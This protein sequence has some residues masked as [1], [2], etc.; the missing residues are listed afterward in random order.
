M[1]QSDPAKSLL[2]KV[3]AT[4]RQYRM[5]EP[6]GG[7]VVGVSG[8]P[9]SIALINILNALKSET[10]FRIV[11]AH[12][13]HGLREDSWKDAEFVREM[14]D[15]MDIPIEVVA[16]DVRAMA[17]N[18]GVSI[19]E[20]GRRCRYKFFED[21]RISSGA[22]VIA[23]AHHMDDEL[24][25]FFLRIF[26][27]S[28][29]RGMKGIAP[30]RGQI[31]RPLIRAERAEIISFLEARHLPYR[32]DPTNL[33]TETD[34]N[35]IRNR[36]F[37]AIRE[38]FSNFRDPLRRTL[39]MLAQEDEFLDAQ[40]KKLCSEAVSGSEDSLVLDVEK[41]RSAPNALT[42][43][44]VLLALYDSS[45][46]DER[47]SR[48]HIQALIKAL[49]SV[50]PSA[51]L[52]LPGGLVAKREYQTLRILREKPGTI[53][54][55]LDMIVTGPGEVEF[56]ETGFTLRFRLLEGDGRFP[57]APGGEATAFFD[58][59]KAAFPLTLRPF[60]PGDRIKP[61]GLDGSR[62]LKKLFIDMKVPAGL[63]RVIP[64]LVKEGE[65]LWVPGIRRGQAAAVTPETRRI[66]EVTLARG[67]DELTD[68]GFTR[69]D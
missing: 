32:V 69:S 52:D 23:T 48:S 12:M 20:A 4:I 24:E 2:S 35:F 62:K 46:R 49:Y 67:L 11:A 55:A 38:R 65:I 25:T 27:G 64:L 41:L 28:S 26:R 53:P 3:R 15:K 61:W 39:A 36:L 44:S 31:V 34:R 8:G 57:K 37:P 33:E 66:L 42:A 43:R 16:Q 21:V 30:V 13:D 47:W 9:D 14:C 22:N 60:R 56:A 68:V 45:G 29:L 59:D 1:T 54:T 17:A 5:I 18:E 51:R 7:V 19:E 63:R 50:N 58:A 40:A 10:G 6:G